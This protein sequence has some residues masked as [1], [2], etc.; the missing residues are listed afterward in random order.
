MKSFIERKILQ[1]SL[2]S[3]SARST[4]ISRPGQTRSSQD[5]RVTMPVKEALDKDGLEQQASVICEIEDKEKKLANIE[6]NNDTKKL[7]TGE[8]LENFLLEKIAASPLH[9]NLAKLC[10]ILK[11]NK[12]EEDTNDGKIEE[13]DDNIDAA[14]IWAKH[15]KQSYSKK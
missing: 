15:Q 13:N 14:K 3:P 6:T 10:Q 8:E 1:E 9:Q 5:I 2:G 12:S 11:P 7:M 4:P